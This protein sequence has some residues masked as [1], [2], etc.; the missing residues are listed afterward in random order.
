MSIQYFKFILRIDEPILGTVC[1]V[2]YA[3]I[4]FSLFHL[5]HCRVLATLKEG[6]YFIRIILVKKLN[7]KPWSNSYK[8]K[9]NAAR[10]REN[11]APLWIALTFHEASLWIALTFN[12]SE[13][14]LQGKWAKHKSSYFRWELQEFYKGIVHGRCRL[15]TST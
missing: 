7:D 12:H 15:N 5:D 4:R 8:L 11:I 9:L 10:L 13:I 1:L 14:T 2:I 3:Y 6:I